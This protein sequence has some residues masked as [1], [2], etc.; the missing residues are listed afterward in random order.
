MA[1]VEHAKEARAA[2]LARKSAAAAAPA[3]VIEALAVDPVL[4]SPSKHTADL[5]LATADANL[6]ETPY[7]QSRPFT[8]ADV[9]TPGGTF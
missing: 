1:E 3:P 5:T 8:E 9:Q 6:L 2:A 4:Y 7:L